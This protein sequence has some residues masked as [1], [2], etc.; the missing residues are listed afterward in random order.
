MSSESRAGGLELDAIAARLKTATP[1]PWHWTD[2]VGDE[3]RALRATD[4]LIVCD[5][6]DATQYYPTEGSE[7]NDADAELIAH[8]PE[9]IAALL[10]EVAVLRTALRQIAERAQFARAEGAADYGVEAL[11]LAVLGAPERDP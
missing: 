5:F 6:G 4:G 8:A 1:G 3:L 11:A 9:D 7:P 2:G 10:A